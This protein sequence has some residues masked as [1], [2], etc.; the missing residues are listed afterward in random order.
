MFTSCSFG[1]EYTHFDIILNFQTEKV[2]KE[3]KKNMQRRKSFNE[4]TSNF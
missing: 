3:E 2:C 4:E 1:K